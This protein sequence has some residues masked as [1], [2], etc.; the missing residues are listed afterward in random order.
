MQDAPDSDR[1]YLHFAPGTPIRTASEDQLDRESFVD[2]VA[3]AITYAP[4]SAEGFT[5]GL[6]GPWGTGK[7]SLLNLIRERL[8]S[9]VSILE[10]NPWLFASTEELVLRYFKEL[11]HEIT[12]QSSTGAA[13]KALDDLAGR[14]ATYGELVAPLS[15]LPYVGQPLAAVTGVSRV[16]K[17]LKRRR[18]KSITEER[19][20]LARRMAT[21][22]KR[23]VVFLDDIDRLTPSEIRDVLRLV[24]LTA[25]FP[26]VVYVLSFDRVQVAKALSSEGIDGQDYLEKI[27]QLPY[28]VPP[29]RSQD[30]ERLLGAAIAR[31]EE[32]VPPDDAQRWSLVRSFVVLPLLQTLRHVSHY[33]NIL[34]I[35]FGVIGDEVN[36]A[37]VLALEAIRLRRTSLAS[38]LWARR[39]YLTNVPQSV[40]SETPAQDRQLR[41]E[42][43]RRH[44][45]GEE[46]M[47]RLWQF[48]FPAT[49]VYRTP[50]YR[51]DAGRWRRAR[52]V[53][54][55]RFFRLYWE[56]VTP[57]GVASASFV[58]SV[59]AATDDGQALSSLLRDQDLAAFHALLST[60]RDHVHDVDQADIATT[61]AAVVN[62]LAAYPS[63]PHWEER[64]LEVSVIRLVVGLFEKVAQA[65]DRDQ[66][67]LRLLAALSSLSGRR[68]ILETLG[69]E[70][71]VGL[72]LISEIAY[73]VQADDL[74]RRI[75]A[76]SAQDLRSERRC[77]RMLGFAGM[78]LPAEA[79]ERIPRLLDDD[80][81]VVGILTEVLSLAETQRSGVAGPQQT[82]EILQ[83]WWLLALFPEATLIRRIRDVAQMSTDALTEPQNRALALAAEYAAGNIPSIV[84][85]MPRESPIVRYPPTED[86]GPRSE[87]ADPPS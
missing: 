14:L 66:I 55:E 1:A 77:L 16:A 78:R 56:R 87:T 17:L 68:L 31:Y 52:R 39:Y 69:H 63:L 51:Y 37:D 57:T 34:A 46:Y 84:R 42:L 32:T 40:T 82:E 83:W 76:A 36:A 64:R 10:F 22:P 27:I 45:V 47:D 80:A 59:L 11:A 72:R 70:R 73:T 3:R 60:M 19:D 21:L 18:S 23:I 81:F 79:A 35:T 62:Q 71:E 85:E 2:A 75:L 24:R 65:H 30:L 13:R 58:R 86:D 67:L 26:N 43:A 6:L 29:I 50:P 49:D 8:A 9:D 15:S 48:L 12:R 7:T 74:A 4:V 20:D 61:L 25:H 38:E 33:A 28:D 54:D 53:A 41:A 44:S 5:I